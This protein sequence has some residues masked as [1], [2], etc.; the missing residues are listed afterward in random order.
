MLVLKEKI[1]ETFETIFLENSLKKD[2][3]IYY[4]LTL[5]ERIESS[6]ESDISYSVQNDSYIQS[7]K[8]LYEKFYKL[9]KNTSN[10]KSNEFSSIVTACR[11][12]IKDCDPYSNLC[13]YIEFLESVTKIRGSLDTIFSNSS[14]LLNNPTID[15]LTA[16]IFSFAKEIPKVIK[17]QFYQ[18]LLD[19]IELLQNTIEVEV[20]KIDM[21]SF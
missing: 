19:R 8:N 2:R 16:P 17:D 1:K 14:C 9:A 7:I 21:P 20:M 11:V 13:S 12:L 4:F 5:V 6:M 3:Q 18:N 10:N 15:S